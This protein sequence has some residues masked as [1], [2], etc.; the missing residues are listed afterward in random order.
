M[1]DYFKLY[2]LYNIT[3]IINNFKLYNLKDIINYIFWNQTD[4]ESL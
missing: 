4:Y 3:Y 2:K 1:T